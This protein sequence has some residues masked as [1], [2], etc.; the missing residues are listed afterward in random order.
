MG[1]NIGLRFLRVSASRSR[2]TY[3]MRLYD[4]ELA[5]CQ[6]R[7][8]RAKMCKSA[9]KYLGCRKASN[10][11]EEWRRTVAAEKETA[12]YG[13]WGQE[14]RDL[15]G[16]QWFFQEV[17]HLIRTKTDS[18]VFPSNILVFIDRSD[19]PPV[20]KG[21]KKKIWKNEENGNVENTSVL[22]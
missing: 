21:M 6:L 8:G 2:I 7:P 5:H 3:T 14:R 18:Y 12:I 13:A 16:V 4:P 19:D 9:L 17:S 15:L 22:I 20:P 11:A 10:F 1:R